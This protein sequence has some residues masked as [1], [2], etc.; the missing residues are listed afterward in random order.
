MSDLITEFDGWQ[1]YEGGTAIA[2]DGSYYYEGSQV[3]APSPAATPTAAQDSSWVNNLSGLFGY[4]GKTA[5][6]TWAG[7]TMMQTSQQGQRYVEGQ[8]IQAMQSTGS[9]LMLILLAGAAF[10]ALR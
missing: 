10:L 7:K 3:W 6:D 9:P 4:A 5:V 8:R 1:Y 2:P